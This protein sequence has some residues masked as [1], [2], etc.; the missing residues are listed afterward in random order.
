MSHKT[1]KEMY[2]E[3]VIVS[4]QDIICKLEQRHAE[5]VEA[6]NKIAV[7]ASRNLSSEHKFVAIIN[8]CEAA[9]AAHKE[10]K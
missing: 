6:L 4:Q 8:I 7:T 3:T 10:A 5:L 9:L 1:E 2:L